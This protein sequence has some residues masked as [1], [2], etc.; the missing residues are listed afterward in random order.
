MSVCVVCVCVLCAC[1]CVLC[2][3]VCVCVCVVCMC[4]RWSQCPQLECESLTW[5]TT[6]TWYLFP[7]LCWWPVNLLPLCRGVTGHP[8]CLPTP[9]T[10]P[11]SPSTNRPGISLS[12]IPG[13]N[14]RHCSVTQ[15]NRVCTVIA[16][17][18]LDAPRVLLSNSPKGGF[19]HLPFSPKDTHTHTDRLPFPLLENAALADYGG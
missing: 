16:E 5:N 13:H 19:Q 18:A 11:L 6:S 9:S 7:L 17:R 10:P 4:V 8:D 3:C 15:L 12:H 1:V 2:A 14:T